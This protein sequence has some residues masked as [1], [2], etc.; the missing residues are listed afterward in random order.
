MI[1][2]ISLVTKQTKETNKQTK[3]NK[4]KTKA[5]AKTNKK[6]KK[7]RLVK[8]CELTSLN[9]QCNRWAT[10]QWITKVSLNKKLVLIKLGKRLDK[11]LKAKGE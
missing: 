5:K 4:T 9:I 3:Q 8:F 7:I 10:R 6:K 11:R 1:S 2:Q